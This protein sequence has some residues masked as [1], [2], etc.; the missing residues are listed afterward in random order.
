MP[1]KNR[2]RDRRDYDDKRPIVAALRPI[3][4]SDTVIHKGDVIDHKITDEPFR[5]RLWASGRAEY[6]DEY[7]PVDV[8][9]ETKAKDKGDDADEKAELI[10]KIK[11]LG[12][13]A[14][15]SMKVETLQ[16]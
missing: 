1:R 5:R 14:T 12:G 6:K 3:N 13:K 9:A 8:A 16:T 11:E 2:I 10:A 7:Q 4:T 15:K